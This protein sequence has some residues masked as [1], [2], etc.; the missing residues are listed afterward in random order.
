MRKEDKS[1]KVLAL[2][3]LE[4]VFKWHIDFSY[5]FKQ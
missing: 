5:I 4:S 1:C 2:K 3:E